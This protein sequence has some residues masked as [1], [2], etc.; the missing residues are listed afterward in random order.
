MVPIPF[1][2]SDMPPS[3]SVPTLKVSGQ[4]VHVDLS[5]IPVSAI[6][7]SNDAQLETVDIARFF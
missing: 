2:G 4:P 3:E 5:M 7:A 1:E 6:S